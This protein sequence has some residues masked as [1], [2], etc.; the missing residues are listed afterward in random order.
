M[1]RKTIPDLDTGWW[2]VVRFTLQQLYPG[3]IITR[4]PSDRWLSGPQS[5]GGGEMPWSYYR[6]FRP[7]DVLDP[8]RPSLNVRDQV[9]EPYKTAGKF[10]SCVRR[11]FCHKIFATTYGL[12]VNLAHVPS[13]LSCLSKIML[14]IHGRSE[15]YEVESSNG[16][17]SLSEDM[18]GFNR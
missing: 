8:E 1:Q 11:I 17:N 14:F 3:G 6:S 7:S 5:W 16:T 2:W 18:N 15:S 12:H 9:S 10:C 13:Y 4:Y